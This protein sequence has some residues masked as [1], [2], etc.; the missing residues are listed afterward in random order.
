MF[1]PQQLAEL[2]KQAQAVQENFKKAQQEL[3]NMLVEGSAGAGLVKVTMTCKND[4][5]R[6]VIDD[7]LMSEDKSMLEDLI[8]AAL[9]DAV[10]KAQELS[11][12]KMSALSPNMPNLS[13]LGL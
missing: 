10:R 5:T 6:V 4:V 2:M 11:S 1:K 13:G 12:Q 3:A 9:N 8:A 7:S